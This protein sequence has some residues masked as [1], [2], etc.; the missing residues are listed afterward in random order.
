MS[1]ARKAFGI[2]TLA[3]PNDYRKAIGL[4]L[5]VRVSNPGIPIA[6]ACSD[7]VRPF[8]APFFDHVIAE[9]PGLKGFVHKVYLDRYS[10]FV[11]T[12]FFDSDVLVFKPVRPYVESWGT[13][14]YYACGHFFSTGIS[15]FGMDW[16]TVLKKIGKPQMVVIDGAGHAFFRQPYCTAVFDLA[17]EITREHK[18]YAG[19]IPYADEDVINIAM[20]MLDLSPAPFGDFFARYMSAMPG[21]MEMDATKARCKFV[22]V[23]NGQPFEPCMVHFAANEASFAYTRQ[24]FALFKMFNVSTRGLLSTGAADFYEREIKL[25]L[26][27]LLGRAKRSLTH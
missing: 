16:P 20:T 15:A 5:S 21:T 1:E 27:G 3:T 23:H 9:Q 19:D 7:K 8:V 18:S 12:M 10:P 6:V 4:A 25:P 13:G 22:A 26:S 14:P 2:L 24:L 11:E 17:R